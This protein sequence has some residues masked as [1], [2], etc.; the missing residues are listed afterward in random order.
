[1]SRP[2]PAL[3]T[4]I[5]LLLAASTA[6][7]PVARA[8]EAP[9]PLPVAKRLTTVVSVDGVFSPDG[10][11]IYFASNRAGNNPEF[12]DIW[13]MNSD[14]SDVRRLTQDPAND[15]M[16]A[17]SPDGSRIAFRSDRTGNAEIF[18]MNSDGS[19]PRQLTHDAGYDIHPSWTPDGSE[20]VFNS[21][22]DSKNKEEPEVFEIYAVRP[23]GSGLRRITTDGAVSTFAS[24]S[25]DGKRLVYRKIVA[26]NSEI[27]VANRDGTGQVN[28]TR[29]EAFDGWP[30]WSPDGK[31]IVFASNRAGAPEVYEIYLM[32]SDGS[33]VRP[34]SDFRVRST[35]P[36][37]SPD[38]KSIVFT[39]S[40]KGFAEM[41]TVPVPDV[42]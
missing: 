1:M 30:A 17:V 36:V 11:R 14:G 26:G 7:W 4:S 41:F 39:R 20:I 18:V 8:A 34:L 12:L 24:V 35:A 21:T 40:G 32:N 28:L 38:G 29:H 37:F 19:D 16:P 2:V 6:W 13:A 5:L 25:P 33:N 15:E 42:P 22:R 27:F 9:A 23:D 31:Q 10:S 3:R